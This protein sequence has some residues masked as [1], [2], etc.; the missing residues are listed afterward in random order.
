MVI[1]G[2]MAATDTLMRNAGPPGRDP[3][4]FYIVPMTDMVVFATLIF[5]AFRARSKPAEHKR[6]IL[7]ATIGLSIA[8]IA[9]W[10]LVHRSAGNAALLSYVFLIFMV[11]YDLW[12]THKLQRATIWAGALLVFVQ[13]IR[14]Y[15]GRT[16][17]WHSLAG[18]V[19]T[20]GR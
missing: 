10:P 16:Q 15:I 2:V 20:L 17:A 5:F 19:Q 18:W 9:R 4:S 12:S 14:P 1:L 6:L 8:A 13:Q 11:L 3:R 7:I